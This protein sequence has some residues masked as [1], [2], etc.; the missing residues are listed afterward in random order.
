VNGL[1]VSLIIPVF[2]EEKLLLE[3]L[4]R[5]ASVPLADKEL[6]VIDDC[7]T[8]GTSAILE[9]I[10][11]DPSLVLAGAAGP[12]QLRVF[13]QADAT[14]AAG[15]EH[16]HAIGNVPRRPQSVQVGD[17][18]AGVASQVVRRRLELVQFLEPVE[19]DHFLVVPEHED[20]AGVVKQNV[21]V[22]DESLSHLSVFTGTTD[23]AVVAA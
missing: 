16:V 8:D 10:E 15:L 5:V 19:R 7:S 18:H 6:I 21:G 13:R 11:K 22:E 17:D 14:A 20:R 2:N 9:R 1:K 3:V 23:G 12:T 4:R